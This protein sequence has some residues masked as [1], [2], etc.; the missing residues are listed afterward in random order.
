MNRSTQLKKLGWIFE[1]NE[2]GEFKR[3]NYME[4][5]SD[6]FN[7]FKIPEH[8]RF[9]SWS[10]EKKKMLI[11]SVLKNYPIHS[12]IC[13]KHFI[14]DNKKVREYLDIEDGQTRLSILQEFYEGGFVD[15]Y[16]NN[17]EDLSLCEK[18]A[19][20]NYEVS[21]EVIEIEDDNEDIIHD[22]FDRLQMGQPLKDCDK[23]WN[24][25]ETPLVKYALELI[26][27][28]IL[29]T[30][31]GTSKFSSQKR[32]RL[33]DTVGLL[34]LIIYWN[35]TTLEYINNSFKSHFKNVK[36]NISD[37]EK[38]KVMKFLKYY[39][40]IIDK[41]YEIYPKV[42]N[43][44]SKKYYNICNDLGL[45]IY[46]YF[47]NSGVNIETRK[48][49]WIKY[50]IYSRKNKNLT[51]GSKQLWNNVDGKP[52]WTQPKYMGCRCSRVIEF[53]DKII[54]G[55]LNEFCEVNNIELEVE[56]VSTDSSDNEDS[57]SD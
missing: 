10:K 50:F 36:K 24:W 18:R 5:V 21:I 43:E 27:S 11:D 45:V 57:D 7:Y 40:S 8:Q 48:D 34:S 16:G 35:I 2:G 46:D 29:N 39:F 41:C 13:S 47:E 23:F 28:G 56:N 6:R 20:E 49:M 3:F 54:N 52:T 9:P 4:R 32:E 26:N 12:I 31:M 22:I 1:K 55:G 17:F 33:S 37:L 19:F 44:K 15:G 53:Y 14:M 25:K 38:E 42:K 30:Y 51:S